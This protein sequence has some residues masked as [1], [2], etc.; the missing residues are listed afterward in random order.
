MEETLIRYTHCGRSVYGF[1]CSE[2]QCPVCHQSLSFGLLDAPVALPCPFRSGH[3]VPCAFLIASAHGP[4]HLGEWH[5]SEIHV[6]LSDSEG[7]VYNY[8]LS[9]VR[10]D[11]RGWERCVCVQLWTQERRESWDRELEQFSSLPQW[12]S[13]RFAEEREFGSCCYG[14][15]LTFINHMRSLDGKQSLSRD[16]FTGSHV[17]P[18]M[19]TVSLYVSIYHAILQHGFYI[20]DTPHDV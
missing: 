8:T 2:R 15:A 3:T 6:G 7:L 13:E 17:L 4:A 1:S 19:K 20:A 5:D 11:E 14:F 10:R 16:Q 9:G 12:A 18:R